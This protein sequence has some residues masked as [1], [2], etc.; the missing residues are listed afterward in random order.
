LDLP[1]IDQIKYSPFYRAESN[2]LLS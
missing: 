1:L 2:Y